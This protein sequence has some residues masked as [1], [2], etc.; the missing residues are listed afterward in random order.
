M[1]DDYLSSTVLLPG[2][3]QICHQK[4][5]LKGGLFIIAE[6]G[7]LAG[8]VSNYTQS[9]KLYEEYQ[10]LGPGTPESE[11]A[12]KIEKSKRMLRTAQML[13]IGAGIVYLVNFADACWHFYYKKTAREEK[14]QLV[15]QGGGEKISL[16]VKNFF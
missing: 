9:E 14:T 5:V 3:Y 13:F 6:I 7:L 16:G 10:A 8:G 11:F 1:G 12:E 15:W 4:N 2:L